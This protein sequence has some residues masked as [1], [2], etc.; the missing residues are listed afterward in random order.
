M[1]I[2]NLTISS[3]ITLETSATSVLKNLRPGQLLQANVITDTAQN[4]V[5]LKI[6][7]AELIARTQISLRA[8]QRITLDVIKAGEMPELRVVK[9]PVIREYQTDALRSILPKQ[10]PMQRLYANLQAVYNN[11]IRSLPQP[12]ADLRLQQP[13]LSQPAQTSTT[14]PTKSGVDKEMLQILQTIAGKATPP[15]LSNQF[16]P[17]L[18][19]AARNI[20]SAAIPNSGNITSTQLRQAIIGYGL[21]MEAQLAAGQPPGAS[22]KGDLLQ[23][24]FQIG[25]LLKQSTGQQQLATSETARQTTTSVMESG[26]TK[27]LEMLF[28]QAEGG[29]A[30]VQLNQL[31]SLPT[32]D[33]TRQV[34]QFEVPVRHQE[35]V[36][37][38]LIRLEQEQADSKEDTQPVWYVTLCFDIEPLGPIQAKISLHDDEVSTMFVAEKADSAEL[39]NRR[40]SDLN[41]AFLDSGLNVGK[42][43]ARRGNAEPEP[44]INII[45][46]PL[47]DEKA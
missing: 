15:A 19:Q 12:G 11:I 41:Q 24:L 46:S 3:R 27:L 28:R 36:D 30:R 22:Y 43:L 1:D 9:E 26:F 29:L 33:N 16:G 38:F 31:A 6:G 10:I 25:N 5:K 40:M 45:G 8:D 35:H 17:K 13:A 21:F 39:L 34:W 44:T 42:L 14:V 37:S 23:L 47:L 32:E 18:V 4:L 2:P 20:L 7:T